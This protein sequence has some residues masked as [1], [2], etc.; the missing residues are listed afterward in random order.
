MDN[1]GGSV[2]RRTLIRRGAIAGGIVWVAPAVTTLSAA[3]A[4]GS[5]SISALKRVYYPP[6]CLRYQCEITDACAECFAT[7]PDPAFCCD[8]C[9]PGTGQVFPPC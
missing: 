7:S 9:K 1:V 5:P 3:K 4:V 2:S 8:T 6:G